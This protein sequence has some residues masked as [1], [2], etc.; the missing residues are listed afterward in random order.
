MAATADVV[1][2]ADGVW[3]LIRSKVAP[4]ARLRYLYSTW[5]ALLDSSQGL[6]DPH[7][8]SFYSGPTQRVGALP[9]SDERVYVFLDAP[10]AEDWSTD[11]G[12]GRQLEE[13]FGGW[14]G[15]VGDTLGRLDDAGVTRL[16]V[17]DLDPL[18]SF[19]AGRVVLIGDAAHATAP[20]LGQGGALAMED[21][22]VLARY[23]NT[24]T[25]SIDAAL[26]RYDSA[27]RARAQPIVMA[28]RARARSMVHGAPPEVDEQH[29]LVRAAAAPEA[30]MSCSRRS[31]CTGPFG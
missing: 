15:P 24:I 23:L 5:L 7:V 19:V 10:V 17:C 21:A 31:P 16:A 4:A 2:A 30:F 13:L 8:F 29:E 3:S 18:E 22:V 14:G 6:T 9:V 12:A 1:V 26:A 28:A 27:R 25:V 20:T 11:A